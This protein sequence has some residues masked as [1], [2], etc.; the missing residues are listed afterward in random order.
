MFRNKPEKRWNDEGKG[1]TMADSGGIPHIHH[2]PNGKAS[3]N[4]LWLRPIENL[5][6]NDNM[7]ARSVGRVLIIGSILVSILY[8][9]SYMVLFYLLLP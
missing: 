8:T 9:A 5:E 1:R 2:N 7:N 3:P 4:A 6:G